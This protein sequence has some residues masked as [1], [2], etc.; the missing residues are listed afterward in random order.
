MTSV[1]EIPGKHRS[2]GL[3][4]ALS[5]RSHPYGYLLNLNEAT[6]MCLLHWRCASNY[7]LPCGYLMQIS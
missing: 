3:A 4:K 1:P 2:Q 7:F 6:R 5:C